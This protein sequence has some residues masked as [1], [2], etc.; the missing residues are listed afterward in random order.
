M[1]GAKGKDSGVSRQCELPLF[2]PSRGLAAAITIVTLAS[3]DRALAQ[4][5]RPVDCSGGETVAAAVAAAKP[6]DT[7]ALR[8]VCKETVII[9]A[10]AT[11]ITLTGQGLATISHP[12]GSTTP[13]PAAHVVYIRGRGITVTGLRIHGG[14]D[15][16]HL[17]G[18]AQAVIHGNLIFDNKGRGIHVDKGSVAQIYDNVIERNGGGGIHITE[19]SMARIGFLIPPQPQLQPNQVRN[20][21]RYGIFVERGSTARIVGN[22]IEAN[23]GAGVMVDRSSEADVA[24]N[25]IGGNSGDAVVVSR[26]SG[27]NFSSEREGPTDGPN[28]T[29][30]ASKNRGVAVRCEVGGYVAGPL[31]TLSGTAGTK[32]FD[33]TCVDRVITR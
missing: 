6:G 21:G 20:N 29:D 17:S 22:R 25:T 7:L 32:V 2:V 24:A 15:G 4:T 27:V 8:G 33:R 12:T 5:T 11:R 19:S 1:I 28:M 3:V 31:G 23:D 16:V 10:E 30:P 13:G 18:P 9:P 14:V 26:N